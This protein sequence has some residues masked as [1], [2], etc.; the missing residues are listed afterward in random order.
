MNIYYWIIIYKFVNPERL[1][2][3]DKC[4]EDLCCYST[5]VFCSMLGLIYF[6]CFI[7][8][9]CHVNVTPSEVRLAVSWNSCSEMI[10]NEFVPE[11]WVS[12][13]FDANQNKSR[14]ISCNLPSKFTFH[15]IHIY[16]SEVCGSWYYLLF[17]RF[18]VS[19][20]M[21]G[22]RRGVLVRLQELWELMILIWAAF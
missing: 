11:R 20:M 18:P 3:I 21:C 7:L 10:V 8:L 13:E 14:A 15:A 1:V 17:L 19:L 5:C 22:C 16:M 9:C 6:S 12:F 2:I 4:R